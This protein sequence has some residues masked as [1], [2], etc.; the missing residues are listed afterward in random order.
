MLSCEESGKVGS[1]FALVEGPVHEFYILQSMLQ[2][3]LSKL[4][5]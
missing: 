5:A 4:E 2:K 1:E 3:E